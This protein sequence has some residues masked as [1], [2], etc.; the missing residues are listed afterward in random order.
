[1]SASQI[2][3]RAPVR[4]A[5]WQRLCL[6]SFALAGMTILIIWI[7]VA[8]L[9]QVGRLETGALGRRLSSPLRFS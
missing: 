1:M 4:P 7:A 3:V 9:L 6:S 2:Q 5:W 8:G